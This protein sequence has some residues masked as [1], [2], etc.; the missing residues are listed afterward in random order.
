MRAIVIKK[1]GDIRVLSHTNIQKPK[2][3]PGH[4]IIKVKYCALNHLD[5]KVR[6]G[7]CGTKI[8]FPHILGSD[9]CGNLENGFDKFNVGDEVVIYPIINDENSISKLNMIGGCSNYNG[10]YAEFVLVP[11]QCIIKKPKWLSSIESCSLNVSYLT[12]WNILRTLDCKKDDE[13]F[14]W[15]GNSGI[16]TASILLAKSIGCKVITTVS[17]DSKIGLVKK[18]GADVVL[19]RKKKNILRSVMRGTNGVDHV[20]DHVGSKTWQTS[21]NMLKAGGKMATC[22]VITG[23]YSKV[24][25]FDVY[26]KQIK[27]FGIYMGNKSQLIEL[28]KFMKLK[29][30]KPIIDSILSLRD[31]R[32]AHKKLE[33]GKQF[34]KIVLRV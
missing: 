6:K 24:N 7:L 17:D 14:V 27:I 30:I 3:I 25:I 1:H 8:K 32:L 13:I 23:N 34:G 33:N 15:G 19:N 12:V 16:G 29:K 2:I 4:V 10:G 11:K 9:I 20:I 21:I 26:N 28:H 18:L 31:A 22:G 5:L